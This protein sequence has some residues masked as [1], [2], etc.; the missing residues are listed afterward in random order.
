MQTEPDYTVTR[1]ASGI[2][3]VTINAAEL[4]LYRDIAGLKQDL[5]A[6][7][8]EKP[9]A[10]EIDLGRVD[11]IDSAGL[12]A[13]CAA[14]RFLV[15]ENAEAELRVLR[16]REAMAELLRVTRLSQILTIVEGGRSDAAGVQP[17]PG[18]VG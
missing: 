16:P 1:R 10:I 5:A 4:D 12:G 2:P 15:G 9:R 17:Q 8:K 6:L 3:L 14:R 18:A 13:L 11:Y 7:A